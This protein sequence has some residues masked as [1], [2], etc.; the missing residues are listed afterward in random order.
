MTREQQDHVAIRTAEILAA[1]EGDILYI[2]PMQS[3]AVP[4]QM[5]KAEALALDPLTIG[6]V[7]YGVR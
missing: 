4:K 5:S 7:G 6:Q 3:G 1:H 2:W